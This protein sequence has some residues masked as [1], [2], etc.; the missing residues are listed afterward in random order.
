M[1]NRTPR[2]DS[3]LES[4]TRQLRE[5]FGFRQFR[6]GQAEIVLAAMDGHDLIVIMPTGSGKSLCFQL[7]ALSLEGTA[8]VVSPLI[9]LMKDQ[10]D[11]LTEQGIKAVAINSTLKEK[12][13]RAAIEGMIAGRYELVYTTP[14]RLADPEF[15][16][17]L[18]QTKIDLFVIDE[19]H[20]VSQW[21]HDFRPEFLGLGDLIDELDRPRVLA[22]T[23]TATPDDIEEIRR[24]L[25]IPDAEVVHTGFHRPNLFLEVASVEGEAAKRAWLLDRLSDAEGVGIIYTA[26]VKG[27]EE[28]TE[29]LQAQGIDAAAYH[30]RLRTALRTE[31][32]ER[33][34]R[35]DLKVLVATNAFGM[36]IDK[37]DIRYV[38]HHHLPATLEAYYQ[39]AGRAGRDGA[40]ARCSLLHDPSDQ[41]LHRFFQAG[42]Y[43]DDSDLTNVHH[44]LKRLA[45]EPDGPSYERIEAISPVR[46]TRLKQVLNHFRKWGVVRKDKEGRYQLL[47]Q[48]TTSDDLIRMANDFKERDEADRLRQEQMVRYAELR[49]CRWEFLVNYLGY[50]DVQ[51][52]ACGHCDRCRTLP[53]EVANHASA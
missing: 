42:R 16:A 7:P 10:T 52:T 47:H 1:G 27:V 51:G 25:H 14:E 53:C 44:A 6:P 8:I 2:Q 41:H 34:M 15:R 38:I 18:R 33:F 29:Y 3:K 31:N 36:G 5:H 13:E 46:K 40:L 32:Q 39:E 9:A 17:A 21:G 48:A 28:L 4:I 26:T 37:P 49:S 50:D 30:G 24:Q 22:L 43:P 12:E 45:D 20:C 19:A 35:G 11:D 23:A